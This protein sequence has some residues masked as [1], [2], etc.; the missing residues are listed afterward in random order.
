M[1]ELLTIVEYESINSSDAVKTK[2]P[3]EQV[4]NHNVL[5]KIYILLIVIHICLNIIPFAKFY[6]YRLY[7]IYFF[8]FRISLPLKIS[9]LNFKNHGSILA[10]ILSY[11]LS[12]FLGKS[13]LTAAQR[14]SREFN[15]F[16]FDFTAKLTIFYLVKLY[17]FNKIIQKVGLMLSVSL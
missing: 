15:T 11:G 13:S 10:P 12:V 6:C 9:K 14:Y 2:D 3:R 4:R 16:K 5:N 1:F 7:V 8:F 17:K